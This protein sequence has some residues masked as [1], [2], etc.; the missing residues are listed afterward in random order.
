MEL[1][2]S[3]PAEND[4]SASL[5]IT[6]PQGRVRLSGDLIN[7]EKALGQAIAQTGLPALRRYGIFAD[8]LPAKPGQDD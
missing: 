8:R 7:I 5:V 1:T 2:F 4:L 3:N 6:T